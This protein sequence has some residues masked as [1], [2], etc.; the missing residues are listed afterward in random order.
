MKHIFPHETVH[1]FELD[2]LAIEK[3]KDTSR[4][5][6]KFSFIIHEKKKISQK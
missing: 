3:N 1:N 2:K 6:I 5:D 4:F